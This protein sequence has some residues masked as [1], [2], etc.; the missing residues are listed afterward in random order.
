[1]CI[2]R[3]RQIS[4]ADLKRK[5]AEAFHS[6][7]TQLLLPSLNKDITSSED[8]THSDAVERTVSSK[9]SRR[10][11]GIKLKTSPPEY[12]ETVGVDMLDKSRVD[13][14]GQDRRG[15]LGHEKSMV[16]NDC[17]TPGE[18]ADTNIS[19][20]CETLCSKSSSA[21]EM[22]DAKR[23]RVSHEPVTDEQVSVVNVG[24]V[25]DTD[26][27]GEGA[28]GAI[29]KERGELSSERKYNGGGGGAL[30]ALISN[31][32]NSSSSSSSDCD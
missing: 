6:S 12:T 14:T 10:D 22:V 21:G 16:N 26:I 2:D 27:G 3:L 32:D 1:V 25:C 30:S 18:R 28:G 15:S 8:K 23:L 13:T 5:R 29:I 4:T 11:F 17:S 31:Y 7:D 9:L 20:P 24:A 19:T